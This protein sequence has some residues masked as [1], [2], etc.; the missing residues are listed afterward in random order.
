MEDIIHETLQKLHYDIK[1]RD[2]QKNVIINYLNNQDV[3]CCVPTGHGKSLCYEL[4]PFVFEAKNKG[5]PS[6]ITKN[7]VLIIQP[8][9]ALMKEQVGKLNEKGYK[10][11]Y[12]GENDTD[13]EGI[14]NGEYNFLF[15]APEV[16]RGNKRELLLHKKLQQNLVLIAVD[17]SHC[18]RKL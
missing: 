6:E 18:I 1:L 16:F 17:E 13:I 7:I 15:A 11:I 8:L 5:M 12:L 3:F 4:A 14:K 10:S 2:F 9:V